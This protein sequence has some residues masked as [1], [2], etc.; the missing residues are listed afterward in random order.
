[1]EDACENGRD[2]FRTWGQPLLDLRFADDILAFAT[3]S[4]QA[5]YLLDELVVALADVGL[6]LN[7]DKTKLI[8]TQV[9]P[10]TTITTPGGLSV[11]VVDRDGC[12]KWLGCSENREVHTAPFFTHTFSVFEPLVYAAMYTVHVVVMSVLTQ[13][14]DPTSANCVSSILLFQLTPQ[15]SSQTFLS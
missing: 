12:H 2:R 13:L 4:Q 1:M 14:S 6:I 8:T 5:A 3:S 11:A 15:V 7:Q 9:Q 10:P